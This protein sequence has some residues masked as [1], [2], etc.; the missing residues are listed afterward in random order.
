MTNGCQ[1]R[2][3]R[4]RKPREHIENN[5]NMF[6]SLFLGT[7]TS[8][9]HHYQEETGYRILHECLILWKKGPDIGMS[10]MVIKVWYGHQIK[11]FGTHIE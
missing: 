6:T 5:Q 3:Q 4:I 7:R 10:N 1:I 8:K 9:L 2:V 11:Q